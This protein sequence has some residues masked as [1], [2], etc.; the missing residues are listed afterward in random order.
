MAMIQGLL[1]ILFWNIRSAKQR[2]NELQEILQNIDVLVCVESWLKSKDLFQVPR[3]VTYRQDRQIIQG[4]GILVR[5]NIKFINKSI[6]G[7]NS[8]G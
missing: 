7:T 6:L 5:K 3:F 2:K 8:K 4:G 1:K